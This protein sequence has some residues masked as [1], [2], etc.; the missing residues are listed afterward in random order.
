MVQK[1]GP[2]SVHKGPHFL[3][4]DEL[5]DGAGMHRGWGGSE[6]VDE[7]GEGIIVRDEV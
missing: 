6:R 4:L 1:C 2:V 5:K 3:L 7:G